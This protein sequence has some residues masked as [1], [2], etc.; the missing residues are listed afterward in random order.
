VTSLLLI[1]V[2]RPDAAKRRQRRCSRQ[3]PHRRLRLLQIEPHVHLAVH[4]R[5]GGEAFAGLIAPSGTPV[6]VAETECS[7]SVASHDVGF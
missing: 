5:G 7:Q 6:E 1:I 4:G 3:L 2:A